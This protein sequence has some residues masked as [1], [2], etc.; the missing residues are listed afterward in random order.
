MS[1]SRVSNNSAGSRF[2]VMPFGKYKGQGAELFERSK[3]EL[4]HLLGE[5]PGA[6]G[7]LKDHL[8]DFIRTA[9]QAGYKCDEL[10]GLVR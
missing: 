9:E 1:N 2:D 5:S 8:R 7:R 4:L 6:A 10:K 3:R